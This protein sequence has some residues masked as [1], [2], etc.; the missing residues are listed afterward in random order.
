M[1]RADAG[2]MV[3]RLAVLALL[4]AACTE[5][6]SDDFYFTY[7]DRQLLC[8]MPIDDY[9]VPT[10]WD[11]LQARID[12]AVAHDWVLNIYAHSPGVTISVQT[13]ERALSMFDAAR[14]PYLTY[15]D[16]D[17][18]APPRAGVV[19]AFDD[20]G[21]E[22]WTSVRPLLDRHRATV[23]LFVTR[24]DLFTPDQRS[25]LHKLEND[26]HVVEAHSMR[27]LEAAVYAAEHGA[28]AY[29]DDEVLPGFAALRADGFTPESFAYP[30]GSRTP[31][32]DALIAP[33]V[34]YL[35]TTPGSCDRD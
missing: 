11:Y 18:E 20:D 12:D 2:S 10:D 15:A 14:L 19:F 16:L 7:D 30:Y 22:S 27:H 25:Q 33:H 29:L 5:P 21:V 1:E 35:R 3:A 31:E 23:T 34:R 13:L 17:P 24:Y 6:V 8:G 32:T 4:L 9:L 28:Q 26:G